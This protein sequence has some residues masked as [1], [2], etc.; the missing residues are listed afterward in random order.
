MKR[1]GILF[2]L[3]FLAGAALYYSIGMPYAGYE[4]KHS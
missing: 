3:I 2:L 4:R 1:L